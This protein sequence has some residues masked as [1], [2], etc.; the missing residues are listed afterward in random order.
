MD[1]SEKSVQTAS[2]PPYQENVMSPELSD[3]SVIASQGSTLV[4]ATLLC[5]PLALAQQ[6]A[7]PTAAQPTVVE[8]EVVV[9]GTRRT[10][11]SVTNS[12][13]PV[14]VISAD[15]LTAQSSANMID[16]VKNL[17]VF[18]ALINEPPP[19]TAPKRNA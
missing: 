12:A 3:R 5:A 4:I 2:T 9:L 10:D 16:A 13:S 11:R 14:D 19:G 8:E 18:W 1:R 17:G 7:A 15:D 6:A